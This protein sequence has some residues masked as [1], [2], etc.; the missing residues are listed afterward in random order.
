[1]ADIVSTTNDLLTIGSVIGSAIL[2]IFG[3]K[4]ADVLKKGAETPETPIV[5]AAHNLFE[6][7]VIA[8]LLAALE[9]IATCMSELMKE[10][11][12]QHRREIS[13]RLEGMEKL[14]REH[15]GKP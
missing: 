5:Q 3:R 12:D 4:V 7:D 2:V 9:T 15:G 11:R 14:L 10:Q 13:E 1:M 8:R 6:K